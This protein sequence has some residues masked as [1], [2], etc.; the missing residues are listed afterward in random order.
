MEIVTAIILLA[1]TIFILF[2]GTARKRR[3]RRT[4]R[5]VHAGRT[6][7]RISGAAWITDGDGLKVDGHIIRMAG[8]DA[9]EH[10][11]PAQRR[12]GEWFNHGRRVKSALIGKIGGRDVEVLT[13]GKDRHGRVLGTVFCDGEDINKWLVLKGFAIAAYGNQYRSAERWSKKKG[14]GMW[15]YGKA[16]DPREWRHRA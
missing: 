3:P 2:S 9:P 1:L 16:Y 7:G 10:D 8:L 12:D 15:G 11:Q 6:T 13:H 4:A 14:L 5:G